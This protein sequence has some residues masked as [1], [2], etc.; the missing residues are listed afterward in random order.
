MS[1]ETLMML[2][3]ADLRSSGSSAWVSKKGP[4][5]LVSKTVRRSSMRV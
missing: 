5:K 1:D 3:A 4:K 2:G